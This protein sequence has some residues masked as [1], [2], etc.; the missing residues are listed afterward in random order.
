MN[1]RPIGRLEAARAATAACAAKAATAAC[2]AV[3]SKGIAAMLAALLLLVIAQTSAWGAQPCPAV[4][5]IRWDAWFGSGGV[6]GQAV[7]KSLGPAQ[8]HLRLPVCSQVIGSN[9]VRIDCMT[10]QQMELESGQAKAAGLDYWAFVTYPED[11]PMNAGLSAY[12]NIRN[13]NKIQFAVISE[14]EKWGDKEAYRP[15]MQR[16][17]RLMGDKSYQRTPD[18]RPIFFLAFIT[19]GSLNYRFGN[20]EGFKKVL[21]EF[22]QGAVNAGLGNPY[23]VLLDASVERAKSF[24]V[25]LGLDGVSAYAVADNRVKSGTFEQLTKL[26]E[27][28]WADAAASGLPVMPIVMSGWDRRPRVRNPVPWEKPPADPK[29]IENYFAAPTP[30]E[31]EHH[32]AAALR[33]AQTSKAPAAAPTV[34]IY[35]WNEFDEGGWIA[36]TLGDGTARLEALRRAVGTACPTSGAAR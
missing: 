8:W 1:S 12:L 19:D 11:N 24:I 7:E 4:G 22:R 23:I 26:T 30:A 18:G 25:D 35:A 17:L 29:Q 20:R 10:P 9:E 34:L 31:L 28:F 36:P 6:P 16:Y 2:A 15:V 13:P 27:R 33:F 5:A 14:F 3:V 21:T 32:I